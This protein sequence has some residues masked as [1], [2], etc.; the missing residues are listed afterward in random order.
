M[1]T[2]RLRLEGKSIEELKTRVLEEHG[3][4]ARI[5]A[6]ERITVGGLAGFFAK[7]HFEVSVEV[8]APSTTGSRVVIDA[9]ARAGI[10]ALLADAEEQE[11]AL[12][13]GSPRGAAAG[14]G[15]GAAGA[16]SGAG[17]GGAASVP[18][19]VGRPVAPPLLGVDDSVPS[20]RT[21]AFAELLQDLSYNAPSP[22]A[23][24]PLVSPSARVP[25]A[26]TTTLLPVPVPAPLRRPGDLVLVVGLSA[27]AVA[28]AGAMAAS[29]GSASVCAS[30]SAPGATR[31]DDRR[32]ALAARAGGVERGETAFVACGWGADAPAI[33]SAVRPDQVWVAVDAGRKPEDTARWVA[34]VASAVP[35]DALAAVGWEDTATP[36]TVEE[37]GLP[38]GWIDDRPATSRAA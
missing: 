24:E 34:A 27:D 16:R 5:V 1:P 11:A 35:I 4:A 12:Q 31:V 17:A 23:P 28:V 7:R 33:L 14:A 10:A 37:L 22:V 6:A 18:G 26:D 15:A 21:P 20:T 19:D 2:T 8:G 30:G 36:E 9:P 38:I 29:V 3:P 32:G 13:L 25:A